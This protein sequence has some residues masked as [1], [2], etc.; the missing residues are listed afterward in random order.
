M[1]VGEDT[2]RLLG[3]PVDGITFTNPMATDITIDTLVG[4]DVTP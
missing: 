3:D 2:I 1:M 4:G